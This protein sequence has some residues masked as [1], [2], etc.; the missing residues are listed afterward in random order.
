MISP[1]NLLIACLYSDL[2]SPGHT[3][4]LR[5]ALPPCCPSQ[6]LQSLLSVS[7]HL[8]SRNS[9]VCEREET[10]KLESPISLWFLNS[11]HVFLVSVKKFFLTL[12][13]N[14]P[15]PYILFQCLLS[16]TSKLH[17]T[18]ASKEITDGP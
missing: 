18:S 13:I 12:S 3:D 6:G 10:A 11:C 2:S 7:L 4:S 14:S 1:A 8:F 9:L 16:P 5:T 17:G 15:I